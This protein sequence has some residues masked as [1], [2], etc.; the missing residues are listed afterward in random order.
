[1]L[2]SDFSVLEHVLDTDVA[3]ASIETRRAE[4]RAGDSFE[5]DPRRKGFSLRGG[6]Q[7]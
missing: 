6:D 1:V 3:P 4:L 7:L 2:A 5:T